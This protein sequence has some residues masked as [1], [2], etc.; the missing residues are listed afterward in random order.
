MDRGVRYPHE[1]DETVSRRVTTLPTTTDRPSISGVQ[2][3]ALSR[4]W[5][6]QVSTTYIKCQCDTSDWCSC[7]LPCNTRSSSKTLKVERRLNSVPTA[8]SIA[9]PR[10]V[11]SRCKWPSEMHEVRRSL[12]TPSRVRGMQEQSSGVVEVVVHARRDHFWHWIIEIVNSMAV[13]IRPPRSPIFEVCFVPTINYTM[14]GD[15]WP[16]FKPMISQE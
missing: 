14:C 15:W 7:R 5:Y 1:R 8:S 4:L 9:L 11:L 2:H 10:V 16:L 13:D 3:E 6:L 12:P